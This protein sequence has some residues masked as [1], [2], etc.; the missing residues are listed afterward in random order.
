[1]G[2]GSGLSLEYDNSIEKANVRIPVGERFCYSLTDA[3]YSALNY[4]MSSYL[5]IYLTDIIGIAGAVVS[6][7]LLVARIFD[8]VNDPIIGSLADRTKSKFGRYKPWVFFG[9]IATAVTVSLMFSNQPGWSDSGKVLF[10]VVVY[11]LISVATT[12]MYIPQIALNSV[13]TS[14][15]KARSNLATWRMVASN[16]GTCIIPVVA[17]PLILKFSHSEQATAKGYS[18]AVFVIVIVALAFGLIGSTVAKERLEPPKKQ[19]NGIPVRKQM[20]AMFKNP[21][22]LLLMICYIV[23]GF[24]AYG[25]GAVLMYYFTYYVGDVGLYGIMGIAGLIGSFVGPIV[26]ASFLHQKLRHKGRAAAVSLFVLAVCY[27][28]MAF[29]NPHH[30]VWWVFSCLGSI[31]Q[32]AFATTVF[33]AVPEACDSGELLSGFRVDGFLASAISFGLKVGGAIGP[34]IYIALYAAA[35]YV[36]NQVQS[37]PVLRLMNASVTYMPAILVALIGFLMLFGYR[38]SDTKHE[39]ILAELRKRREGQL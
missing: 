8:A 13:M 12:S 17:M 33:A 39:E 9:T 38:I 35:G 6:G 16:L 23:H 4:L 5:T 32:G 22:I 15:A 11:L 28:A 30:S 14:N 29:L 21:A 36:P 18:S 34:A 24:I 1:M 20:Q 7:L 27:T 25:R 3:G 37:M 10:A 2:D 26:V 31:C 19:Q